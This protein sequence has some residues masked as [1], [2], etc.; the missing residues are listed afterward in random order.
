M[1]SSVNLMRMG[2]TDRVK[3]EALNSM[4]LISITRAYISTMVEEAQGYKA[5]VVDKETMRIAS[6]LFGRTE[7]AEHN[8][9]HI[10]K[11][12]VEC[13]EHQELKVLGSRFP[14]ACRVASQLLLFSGSLLPST[15]EGQHHPAQAGAEIP[16]LPELLHL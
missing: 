10:E 1:S 11:I 3:Q 6:L 9:V 4:D 13:K 14:C 15:D 16:A 8:V 7:L 12:E 2:T 5:L